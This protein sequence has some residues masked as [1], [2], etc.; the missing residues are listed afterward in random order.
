MEEILKA[1]PH[2]PPF[3]FVDKIIEITDTKIK[4]TRKVNPQEE[5]FKGHYPGNPIMPG[6]L[7]CEAIFQSGA[8]L[9]SRIIGQIDDGIPVLVRINNARLKIMVKPGDTLEL[10]AEVVE[11]VSSAYFLKGKA[12]VDG[13]TAATVE[14]AVTLANK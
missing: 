11:K 9:L 6:V 8:I 14:F 7:V 10:E 4:A 3:L 5:Y 13:R 12:S 2:R 1:I